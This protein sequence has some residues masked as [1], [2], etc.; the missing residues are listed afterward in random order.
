MISIL[1]SNTK[2]AEI[3]SA[4]ARDLGAIME[5]NIGTCYRNYDGQKRQ[6]TRV[7]TI[8][9]DM[10]TAE[11]KGKR[12]SGRRQQKKESESLSAAAETRTCIGTQEKEAEHVHRHKW[13]WKCITS[14][15]YRNIC[16]KKQRKDRE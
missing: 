10:R 2:T 3:L 14:S 5:A 15:K 11:D 4:S 6:E 12:E 8:R 1:C 9:T 7:R 16:Q 13:I